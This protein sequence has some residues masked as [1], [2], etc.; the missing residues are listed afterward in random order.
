MPQE[1]REPGALPE[2]GGA[3]ALV[4]ML[5]RAVAMRVGA[6]GR[7]R[8]PPGWYCYVG[9][10]RGGLRARLQRHLRT[11]GKRLHWH[12]DHLRQHA[13][14]VGALVWRGADADECRL[15]EAVARAAESSV[16]GFGASDCRCESHLHYFPRDPTR[17]LAPPTSGRAPA[18]AGRRRVPAAQGPA[19][20]RTYPFCGGCP[21]GARWVELGAADRRGKDGP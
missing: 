6:L 13:R 11:E 1:D 5:E 9:S 19:R 16:P 12:V 3:Y 17:G 15:S 10:A 8:F 20:R 4:L 2:E 7:M 21:P 14:P 18:H